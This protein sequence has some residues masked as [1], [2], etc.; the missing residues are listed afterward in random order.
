MRHVSVKSVRIVLGLAAFLFAAAS[1]AQAATYEVGPGKTY[2][3]INQVPWE[4][5]AA[6]DT[7]KIYYR[8]TAY[9]S[10]WVISAA[11]TQ[12]QPILIQGVPDGGGALPVIDG[13]GATTRLELSYWN[14]ERGIINLGHSS[15]PPDGV[16]KYLTFENLEII[17]GRPPYQYTCDEGTTKSYP[18]N[19]TAI[20]VVCGENITVRN[21]IFRQ[22]GNGFFSY[23]D[24]SVQS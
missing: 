14:D 4:N 3:E 17:G 5:I 21:C 22:N 7:V 20:W 11:G 1:L 13:N 15:I 10:K 23:S 12:S 19:A 9:K 16:P 6:G 24:D 18:N 8:A 2:T